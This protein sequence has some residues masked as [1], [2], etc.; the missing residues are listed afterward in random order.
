MG[1]FQEAGYRW[2]T[3]FWEIQDR[4]LTPFSGP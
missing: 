2:D 1:A 3:G 4:T